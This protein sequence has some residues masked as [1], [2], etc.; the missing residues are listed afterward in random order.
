MH[1]ITHELRK[2]IIEKALE[3]Y[4]NSSD[5]YKN[6]D[7]DTV[8]D[9]YY[10]NGALTDALAELNI[11]LEDYDNDYYCGSDDSGAGITIG[12]RC[13]TSEDDNYDELTGLYGK[14]LQDVMKANGT[15]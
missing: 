1:K 15:W 12:G 7:G 11:D 14:L 3:L 5:K 9:G 8:N 6:H 13:F 2:R 10:E 4:E